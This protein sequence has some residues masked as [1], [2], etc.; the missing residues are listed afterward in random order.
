MPSTRRRMILVSSLTLFGGC[1]SGTNDIQQTED[2]NTTTE[3]PEQTTLTGTQEEL[4][5]TATPE[6]DIPEPDITFQFGESYVD[7]DLEIAV[8][9]PTIHTTF[10]HEGETYKMPDE[11]ALASVPV[12]FY[13]THSEEVRPIDGPIFTLVNDKITTLETHSVSHPEFSPSIRTRNME[14]VPTVGRWNTHG[15]AIE[16]NQRLNGTAVFE[17]PETTA[18]TTLSIVYESDRIKDD[19]FGDTDVEWTQ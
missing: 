6:K 2:E 7:N 19:R 13:N 12:E 16:P 10:R 1:T 3:T 18:Q 9:T 4:A 8:E 14:G 15:R 5:S 17:V 11:K